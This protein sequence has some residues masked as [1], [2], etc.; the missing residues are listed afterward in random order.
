MSESLAPRHCRGMATPDGLVE[1]RR[2]V[3]RALRDVET[4]TLLLKWAPCPEDSP[5]EA[6]ATAAWRAAKAAL[7]G[8]LVLLA[9]AQADADAQ[10]HAERVASEFGDDRP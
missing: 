4:W 8:L 1:A 3:L 7:D 5:V 9:E 2:A 6:A 10:E